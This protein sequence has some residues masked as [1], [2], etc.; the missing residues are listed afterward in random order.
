MIKLAPI[1]NRI[2]K[3]ET[4]EFDVDKQMDKLLQNKAKELSFDDFNHWFVDNFMLKNREYS[5]EYMKSRKITDIGKLYKKL[6][7]N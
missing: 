6:T 4:F 7:N 5:K 1:V 3:E 2:L